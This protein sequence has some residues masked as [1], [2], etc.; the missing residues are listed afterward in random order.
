MR[1]LI[2]KRGESFIILSQ[3]V[4]INIYD[5]HG[6]VENN[7]GRDHIV[8]TTF[9][10]CAGTSQTEDRKAGSQQRMPFALDIWKLNE[11]Y[12]LTAVLR[13]FDLSYEIIID[14]Q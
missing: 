13:N 11:H 1:Y 7:P 2:R 14:M 4:A 5:I 8:L 10:D 6:T 12:N 9:T 3:C